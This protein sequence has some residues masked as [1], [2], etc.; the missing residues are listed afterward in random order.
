MFKQSMRKLGVRA[1]LLAG[2]SAAVLAISGVGATGALAAP[3]CPTA[4]P[5]VSAIEGQGSSLQRIA[6]ELWTGREVPSN[7]AVGKWPAMPHALKTGGYAATCGTSPS[8]NYTSTGSGAAL[9]ALRYTGTGNIE[10]GTHGEEHGTWFGGSDDGPNPTQIANAES[11]AGGA[12]ALIIPVAQTSIAVVLH[13]P[14]GCTI[15]SNTT[16]GINYAELNKIFSGKLHL[17]SELASASG[18]CSGSISRVV[19][20]DGSGTSTQLKNY[21]SELEIAGKGEAPGCSLGTWAS[22]RQIENPTTSAPNTTWPECEGRIAVTRKNG[23]GALAEYVAKTE[24]T[25][26]YAALPDAKAKGATVAR[27]QNQAAGVYA[28]PEGSTGETANC[29]SRVYSVPTPGQEGE[30]GLSVN[31]STV[32][33]AAPTVG[34]TLYPLCT[35]TYDLSWTSYSNAGYANAS[36]AA[37]DAKA[38]INYILN[39]GQSIGHY[40]Q[41]LP[42]P[43]E[44]VHNVL[45][46]AKLAASKIG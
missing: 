22:L 41:A 39:E 10:N 20:E 17:W 2:A 23:G 46:A 5:K 7:P 13:A 4:V 45:G 32:F 3:T 38:F 9:K 29:G 19:R 33:G 25:I 44:K 6:Q 26:G 42:Q 31:W 35:L 11:A 36:G 40:Y 28:L 16:H 1:G 8:I 34:G 37:E 12:K 43:G 15:T 21:L 24:G 27:L 14:S 30:T 18:T